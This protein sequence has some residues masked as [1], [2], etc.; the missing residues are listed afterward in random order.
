MYGIGASAT[1]FD[2]KNIYIRITDIDEKSRKLNYQNLTT[3]DELNNKY[4][5]KR[6]DI[7]FARTGA[8]TGKSYIHKE[9]KDIYNYYFAEF[10]NK[11]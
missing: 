1:R 9:E 4:K 8:S 7:L 6:N 11:I 2:S 3:P 10:F 5:L